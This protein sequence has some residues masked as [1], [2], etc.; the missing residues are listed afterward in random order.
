MIYLVWFCSLNTQL[1]IVEKKP[2]RFKIDSTELN[3]RRE[4]ISRTRALVKVRVMS[5]CFDGVT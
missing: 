4:F 5:V 2:K 3:N 1:L